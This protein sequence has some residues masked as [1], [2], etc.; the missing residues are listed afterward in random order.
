MLGTLIVAGVGALAFKLGMDAQR[1]SAEGKSAGQIA[2][3]M[4]GEALGIVCHV[5]KNAY[6]TVSGWF[7]DGK[8]PEAASK[9]PAESP[10]ESKT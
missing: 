2:A 5:G 8:K 3:E 1:K 10:P 7:G 6:S 4:P 9:T